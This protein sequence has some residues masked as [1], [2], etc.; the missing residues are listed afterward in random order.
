MNFFSIIKYLSPIIGVTS[1]MLSFLL[2]ESQIKF[3]E[4]QFLLNDQKYNQRFT[5]S[6]FSD[7]KLRNKYLELIRNINLNNKSDRYC[8]SFITHFPGYLEPSYMLAI[9]H[10]QNKQF[11]KALLT[12]EQEIDHHPYYYE[13][14]FLKS[15]IEKSLH[16][17]NE[18]SLK[19]ALKL[20]KRNDFFREY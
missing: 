8:N 14:Y 9:H 17:R 19:I 12:I 7:L 10:Y 15:K 11:K 3:K 4:H 13:N 5:I 16:I 18:D 2:F 6:K 20:K 1:L